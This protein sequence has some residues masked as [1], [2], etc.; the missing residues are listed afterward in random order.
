MSEKATASAKKTAG[1]STTSAEASASSSDSGSSSSDSGSSSSD[2]GSTSSD[3]GSTSTDGGSTSTDGGATSG[4]TSSGSKGGAPSRA[5]SYFSSVSTDDY[6][7]GWDN[8]F[9]N[10]KKPRR[11]PP[12]TRRAAA[13][14][15]L[16]LEISDLDAVLRA[17][18]ED[19][20]RRQAK[21][22]RIDYDKRAKSWRLLCELDG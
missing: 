12:R 8:V 16:E 18:L 6:R 3:S 20:F 5:I 11:A 17:Q 14:A 7:D 19:A 4:S 9:N 15:T 13:P 22:R 2:S 1:K 10:K 21:T